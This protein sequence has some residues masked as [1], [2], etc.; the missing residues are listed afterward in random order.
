MATISDPSG[1]FAI[2]SEE[3]EAVEEITTSAAQIGRP[4]VGPVFDLLD[5]GV[6]LSHESVARASG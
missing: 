6:E 4:S 1:C 3:R 2:D 5:C